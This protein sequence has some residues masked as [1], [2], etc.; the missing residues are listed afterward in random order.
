MNNL[1]YSFNY[2]KFGINKKIKKYLNK[3]GE[4]G[5]GSVLSIAVTII[6][7]A[8]IFLP[9][10]ESFANT[11]FSKMESWWG[12]VSKEIFVTTTKSS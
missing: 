5:V 9:G 10:M 4:F 1:L 3:R 6:I 8:F 12:T 7:V 2:V 11:L